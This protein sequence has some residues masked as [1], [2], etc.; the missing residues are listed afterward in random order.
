MLVHQTGGEDAMNEYSVYRTHQ[1]L[2]DRLIN[3]IE[4]AYLGKNDELRQA[5]HEELSAQGNLWQEPYI[6]ANP[7]YVSVDNGIIESK[8]IPVDI[9]AILESMI[10]RNMGVFKNPYSHQIKSLERFYA[11]DELFVATGTG[12]GKTECFM[13]PMISKLIREAK[14]SSETWNQRGIRAM[15]MYPMNALVADQIGRLRRMI[16]TEQ[17]YSLFMSMTGSRRRPQFGMYT[18]RTP[19][20]GR[21][22]IEKDKALAET[23]QKNLI[24]RDEKVRNQLK[25]MG[26]YPA[27]NDLEGYIDQ[28]VYGRHITCDQDAEM[29]TRFEM[30]EKTPDILITNY[31][32]LEY[33]LMRQ[34]EQ[35]LW[36]DT[37]EWLRAKPENKLLFIIDEAHMY[38]GASGGEV[39]LLLRRFFNTETLVFT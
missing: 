22:L 21:S 11:G 10:E 34:E 14:S 24:D 31:S 30:Q 5:C 13:W 7:A 1:A 29:I 28:L 15:M 37:K 25:A 8:E 38:R 2:K 9:K 6:E 32:M 19:Y 23:L 33:M 18:G 26:K 3:Y 35:N 36:E 20:A 12:S 39:A 27:K 17:F 4:T 16:G